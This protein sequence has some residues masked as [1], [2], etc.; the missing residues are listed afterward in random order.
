MLDRTDPTSRAAPEPPL[1][2]GPR[3]EGLAAAA[4]GKPGAGSLSREG[5][6]I[7]SCRVRRE[8]DTNSGRRAIAGVLGDPKIGWQL[9]DN[10]EHL[11][12]DK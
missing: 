8:A 3:C 2:Q 5:P 12:S 10:R 11:I 4:L 7:L 9:R 6:D 1:D